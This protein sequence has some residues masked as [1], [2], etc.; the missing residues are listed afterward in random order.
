MDPTCLL[1]LLLALT[2][3]A[4]SLVSDDP[5]G[6]IMR[7]MPFRGTRSGSL[8]CSGL[9]LIGL[10]RKTTAVECHSAHLPCHCGRDLGHLAETSLL[11]RKAAGFFP[12]TIVLFRKKSL[13]TPKEWGL[14]VPPPLDPSSTYIIWNSSAWVLCLLSLQY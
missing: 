10:G 4:T 7:R 6:Q 12:S 5:G 8:F 1:R 14:N 9:G 3:S 2:V 11:H 13:S